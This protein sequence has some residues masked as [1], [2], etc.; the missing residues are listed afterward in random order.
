MGRGRHHG[1]LT[2]IIVIAAGIL[3]CEDGV[4]CHLAEAE[5]GQSVT[6]SF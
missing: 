3:W 5:A 2:I 1:A 6:F 4:L